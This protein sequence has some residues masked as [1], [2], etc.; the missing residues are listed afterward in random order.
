MIPTIGRSSRMASVL[1]S[2]SWVT[3]PSAARRSGPPSNAM[4]T[5]IHPTRSS[6]TAGTEFRASP[7]VMSRMVTTGVE[8]GFHYQCVD[9]RHC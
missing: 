9:F 2:L 1:K 7:S 6:P 5:T 3:A 4:R 8:R